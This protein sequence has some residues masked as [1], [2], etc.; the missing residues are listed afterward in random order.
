ME[1]WQIESL[2]DFAE[3]GINRENHVSKLGKNLVVYVPLEAALSGRLVTPCLRLLRFCAGEV[4]CQN[5][6]LL[7]LPTL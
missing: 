7:G 1:F 2:D 4:I 6:F 3:Q 5:N